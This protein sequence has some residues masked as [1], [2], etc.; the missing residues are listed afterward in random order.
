[1][2][3]M[4]VIVTVINYVGRTLSVYFFSS[5]CS[6]WTNPPQGLLLPKCFQS[7][8]FIGRVRFCNLHKSPVR[9]THIRFSLTLVM[10]LLL[11]IEN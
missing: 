10:F 6:S 2:M 9:H 4:M 11:V 1:M 5:V 7:F 8:G 3:M